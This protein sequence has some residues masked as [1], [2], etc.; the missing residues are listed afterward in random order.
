MEWY[1]HQKTHAAA[2]AIV[3]RMANLAGGQEPKDLYRLNEIREF[4]PHARRMMEQQERGRDRSQLSDEEK[5]SVKSLEDAIDA[6][7]EEAA[8]LERKLA[9][10][11]RPPLEQLAKR[12]DVQAVVGEYHAAQADFDKAVGGGYGR[13]NHAQEQAIR[14]RLIRAEIAVE[15]FL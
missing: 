15:K 4:V 13:M 14:Q 5:A 12:A 8:G 10:P 2:T 11:S 7:L 9:M 6:A 1:L 3:Q